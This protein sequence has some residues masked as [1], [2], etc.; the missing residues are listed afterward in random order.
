MDQTWA[1]ALD[2]QSLN[3]WTTRAISVYLYS[4]LFLPS[5]LSLFLYTFKIFHQEK[6][7]IFIILTYNWLRIS[8]NGLYIPMFGKRIGFRGWNK[9][10]TF[11]THSLEGIWGS[12][13]KG[14]FIGSLNQGPFARAETTLADFN[15]P[16]NKGIMCLK[17]CLKDC[18]KS[19]RLS[20]QE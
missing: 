4:F 2:V 18:R 1:L 12:E 13:R 7:S 11:S 17:N 5:F 8:Y 16:L 9:W 19:P 3:H 14:A 20:F 15:N 6:F 10:N